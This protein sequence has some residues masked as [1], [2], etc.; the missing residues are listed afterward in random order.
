[1]KKILNN[2][3]EYLIA[4]FLPLMC[5]IVFVNTV[6]RYTGLLSLP[7]A[8]EAAR[9]L[10]VWLVF[11]GIA[12]AAKYNSH[13]AVE[14]LFL[15]TPNRFHKYFRYLI[16]VVVIIFCLTVAMLAFKFVMNLY[17][18]GQVSPSLQIPMW[19]MY[20]AIPLGCSLMAIRTL[21]H[22]A[23]EKWLLYTTT[24]LGIIICYMAVLFAPQYL[25]KK[26]IIS[27]DSLNAAQNAVNIVAAI[28]SVAFMAVYLRKAKEE[29]WDP[30]A[31]ALAEAGCEDEFDDKTKQ[32]GK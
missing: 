8:E 14:V 5:I 13:F 19:V 32:D 28:I 4:V 12:A 22:Y 29:T 11:L 26:E 30:E 6:G 27:A 17:R 21:Q 16:S 20:S 25:L 3:E 15:I 2:V 1:M 31:A 23:Q 18:M 7:W 10:M 24:I 9:Y